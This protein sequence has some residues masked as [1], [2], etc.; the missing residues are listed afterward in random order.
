MVSRVSKW[1]NSLGVR[2]T[3]DFAQKLN[4]GEN[5]EVR[6]TIVDGKL[7]IEALAK[8]TYTLTEMLDSL[9]PNDLAGEV[10]T[11][12]AVGNEVWD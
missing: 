12:H 5:T 6:E 7:V 8:R 9:A 4:W 10:N 1:G 3:K 2:I 11:G